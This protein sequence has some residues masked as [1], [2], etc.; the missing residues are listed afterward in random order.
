MRENPGQACF[1]T[2]VQ[3]V[4]FFAVSTPI[5]KLKTTSHKEKAMAYNYTVGKV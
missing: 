3:L 5:R 1:Y 2:N 4:H